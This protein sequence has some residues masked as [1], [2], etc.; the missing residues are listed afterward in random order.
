MKLNLIHIEFIQPLWFL[1][2]LVIPLLV[3][4]QLKKHKNN[5]VT[6]TYSK[7]P[8]VNRA[9]KTWK[10][11]TSFIPFVL[12]LVS[13]SFFIIAMARPVGS[14]GSEYKDQIGIDIVIA[15]DISSSMFA[16][17]LQPTRLEAAKKIAIEFIE[18]RETDRIGFVAFAGEAVSKSPLTLDHK[19]LIL[20][21]QKTQL[22]TIPDGTAI[23]M[24]LGTAVARLEK[25][26]A[27]SKVIILL[28]DGENNAGVISPET[29]ADLA[30]TYGIRVYTIGVGTKG[31]AL[32]TTQDIFGNP[33]KDYMEVNIDEEL[34]TKIAVNTGGKYFRAVDN[35]S[36]KRIFNDIDLLEKSKVQT[37]EYV[38]KPEQFFWFVLIGFG[39]LLL[40]LFLR[41]FIYKT[42]F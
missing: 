12:R 40:E 27:V 36:L 13:L 24:G 17:D 39:F 20:K 7:S 19:N 6:L 4:W 38:N 21:I 8:F 5:L 34:L 15:M 42:L 41:H 18:N 9:F 30:K 33:V 37:N 10:V 22:G 25:S 31:R 23:G 14:I 16:E 32:I 1:L 3:W 26:D 2:F 35:N 29:A 28:T 11:K